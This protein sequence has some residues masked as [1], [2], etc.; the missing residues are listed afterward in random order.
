MNGSALC[1]KSAVL[2][3]LGAILLLS[4]IAFGNHKDLDIEC[5]GTGWPSCCTAISQS[6][7]SSP[8]NYFWQTNMGYLEEENTSYNW[9]HHHCNENDNGGFDIDT[10]VDQGTLYGHGTGNC[11]SNMQ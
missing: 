2:S 3:A 4:G 10:S 8:I 9:N 7:G 6:G 1:R 11:S 5:E